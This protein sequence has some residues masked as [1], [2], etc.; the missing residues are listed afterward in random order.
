ML[1]N[2]S[3]QLTKKKLKFYFENELKINLKKINRV[4]INSQIIPLQY[5][6]LITCQAWS[7]NMNY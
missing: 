5:D 1:T 7:I 3:K 6:Q 4:N 2:H